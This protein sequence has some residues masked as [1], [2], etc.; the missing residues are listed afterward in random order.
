MTNDCVTGQKNKYVEMSISILLCNSLFW[1]SHHEL[2]GWHEWER[3]A[4]VKAALLHTQP[5]C[6]MTCC[7]SKHKYI[8]MHVNTY[9]DATLCSFSSL[10]PGASPVCRW[11]SC[12]LGEGS[13]RLSVWPSAG[14]DHSA[15]CSSPTRPMGT[16]KLV[17]YDLNEIQTL[18]LQHYSRCMKH[19]WRSWRLCLLQLLRAEAAS[20]TH[21]S[22]SNIRGSA[23]KNKKS[24]NFA[25]SILF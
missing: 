10:L 9:T 3:T 17:R 24:C 22:Q 14:A 25:S 12:L 1:K 20:A 2:C 8:N 13:V 23:A 5:Q 15:R 21:Y 7:S 19:Q 4:L 11:A 6:T 16:F 18:T